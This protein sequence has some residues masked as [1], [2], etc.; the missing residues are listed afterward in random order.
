MTDLGNRNRLLFHD[1]MNRCPIGIHHFVEFVNTTDAL[2][3]KNQSTTFERHLTGNRVLHD[4]SRQTDTRRTTA[5]RV[6][7]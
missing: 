3:G 6:L 2:I 5:G 1:L 7:T 4:G